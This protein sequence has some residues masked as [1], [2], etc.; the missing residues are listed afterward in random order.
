MNII[1]YFIVMPLGIM[2]PTLA[3]VSMLDLEIA[4]H[5]LKT[6][7]LYPAQRFKC[8]CGKEMTTTTYKPFFC[9]ETIQVLRVVF[10]MKRCLVWRVRMMDFP[11][12][13]SYY[14][15]KDAI[16]GFYPYIIKNKDIH[17]SHRNDPTCRSRF[18]PLIRKVLNITSQEMS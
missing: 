2:I 10:H 13:V 8:F 15:V 7:Q 18:A 6:I 17:E 3:L 5:I 11:Y 12:Q 16:D 4:E 14:I 1:L 9:T